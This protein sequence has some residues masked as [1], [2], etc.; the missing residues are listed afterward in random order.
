M[1]V[2]LSYNSEDFWTRKLE[3]VIKSK[4][5][6]KIIGKE[7][8]SDEMRAI[9]K[10]PARLG[11]LGFQNPAEEAQFEYENSQIATK[12]LT[13]AITVQ[14][15]TLTINTMFEEADIKPVSKRNYV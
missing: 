9:M 10:L 2:C 12:Q 1:A 3:E 8:C 5:I 11:G 7:F 14:Q 15:A 13:E 6:P 4:L